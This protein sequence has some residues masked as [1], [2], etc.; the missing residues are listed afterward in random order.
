M[1]SRDVESWSGPVA[2][3]PDRT[4]FAIG[5]KVRHAKIL[6][7]DVLYN[8]SFDIL[9]LE[10]VVHFME[11][12]NHDRLET[13]SVVGFGVVTFDFVDYALWGVPLMCVQGCDDGVLGLGDGGRVGRQV[14]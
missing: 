4:D 10:P 8:G 1:L 9:V 3:I 5:R 11:V 12:S 7:I 14:A 13:Y 2:R 6:N